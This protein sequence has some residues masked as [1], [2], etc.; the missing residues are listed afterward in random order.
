MKQLGVYLSRAA[1]QGSRDTA[2]GFLKAWAARRFLD[3]E[4]LLHR[5]LS[6]F[7]ER[8]LPHQWVRRARSSMHQLSVSRT[9]ELSA[10]LLWA[11]PAERRLLG[12]AGEIE[13]LDAVVLCDVERLEIAA[14]VGLVVRSA[15]I[16]RAFDPRALRAPV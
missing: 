15:Q 7:G 14:T 11:L 9:Q 8:L 4:P 2:E 12:L 3:A 5:E 13:A 6:W 1:A 10:E 16:V